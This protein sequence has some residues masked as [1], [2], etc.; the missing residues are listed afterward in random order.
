LVQ[1]TE[2][3]VFIFIEAIE[4]LVARK[5][6]LRSV[7][8]GSSG[9]QLMFVR[10]TTDRTPR[11]NSLGDL[12]MTSGSNPIVS[13]NEFT[14]ESPTIP[15]LWEVGVIGRLREEQKHDQVDCCCW[16]RVIGRN[17]G[18]S[19]D[20]CADSSAGGYDHASRCRLRR[21]QDTS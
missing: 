1:L 21:W 3:T 20:A 10:I 4:L 19:Y 9:I 2:R 6:I 13:L 17:I 8:F 11:S 5:T 15:V 18:A 14:Y 7:E 16:L 12:G